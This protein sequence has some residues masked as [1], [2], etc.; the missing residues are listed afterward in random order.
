[1]KSIVT[2]IVINA[3]PKSIWEILTQLENYSKW[4]P[5]IV[6]SSGKIAPGNKIKNTMK[7]GDKTISFSPKILKVIPKKYF[8]WQ[9]HLFFPGLFDGHHYFEITSINE[10]QSL[11]KHGENFNGILSSFILKKI[12]DETR[13]NFIAMNQAIKKL[14]EK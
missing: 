5:F 1:M 10:N 11:L 4:N 2:E 13:S 14:A 3:T 6:Q 9:G 7:N 12:G 8:D